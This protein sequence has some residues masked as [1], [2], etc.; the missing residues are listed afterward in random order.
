MFVGM[1]QLVQLSDCKCFGI[2]AIKGII[3]YN[4]VKWTPGN[5]I[6]IWCLK[7][8][9]PRFNFWKRHFCIT[10]EGKQSNDCQGV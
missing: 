3:N 8:I 6:N 5:D 2:G 7:P 9:S 1:M 4:Q 10:I